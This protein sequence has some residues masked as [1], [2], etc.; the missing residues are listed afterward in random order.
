MPRAKDLAELNVQLLACSREDEQRMI[1]DRAQTVG[2]GMV[3]EREH[4][5]PLPSEGFPL[6]EVCF[7]RGG[8][9]RLREGA[10]ELVFDAATS[11]DQGAGR[12]AA[13][14]H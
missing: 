14:L 2:A 1:G 11:R 3:I 10:H 4:L 13:V 12:C 9:Q 7:P 5:L 8:H 6:S